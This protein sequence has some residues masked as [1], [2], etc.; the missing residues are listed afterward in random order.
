MAIATNRQQ[1]D[2]LGELVECFGQILVQGYAATESPM[3][4][5][6]LD[7]AAHQPGNAAPCNIFHRLTGLPPVSKCLSPMRR[8]L[9]CRLAKPVKFAFA[10]KPPKGYY[11]N[12]EATAA[13][14]DEGAWKSGDIG[15]IAQTRTRLGG[16]KAPKSLVFVDEL[17]TSVVGKVLRR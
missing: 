12:P 2:K 15:Y 6:A 14:F 8:A 3:M 10:A 11:E 13:E 7:K 17:P 1:R 9:R 4:I 5:A 16:Y